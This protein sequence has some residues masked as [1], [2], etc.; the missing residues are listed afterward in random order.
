M[1]ILATALIAALSFVA[2]AAAQD[3]ARPRTPIISVSG[4]GEAEL[5]PDFARLLVTVST[6]ADTVAPAVDANRTATERVLGRIQA[7][8][9]KR[10][11]IR[12]QNFQ[13]FQTPPRVGPDGRE[14]KTPRFTVNHQLRIVTRDIE[15]V[16]KLTGA[17][18]GSD[19]MMFQSLSWGL[20]RQEEGADEA[21]RSAVRDARRQ[22]EVYAEAAQVKLGRLLEIRDGTARPFEPEMAM[23]MRMAAK[24]PDAVP[25]VPPATVRYRADVQMVWEIAP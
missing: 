13:V 3:D 1:R 4:T 24:A 25:I 15:G 9:I 11:D 23:P 8:G 2:P 10:E 17:I 7:L 18:V 5:K 22:A 6:Q 21:R 20:D 16:G 12:T 19:D 14:L